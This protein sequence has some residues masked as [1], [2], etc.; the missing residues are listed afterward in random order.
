MLS[1]VLVGSPHGSR[2]NQ[3]KLQEKH[4]LVLAPD[5][6]CS[7]PIAKCT[8]SLRKILNLG[9][10]ETQNMT[11]FITAPDGSH[12]APDAKCA[13]LS[14]KTQD[15]KIMLAMAPDGSHHGSCLNQRK[16]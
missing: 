9:I 12:S 1:V 4:K 8:H 10:A 11:V 3:R 15:F 14:R 7:A 6:S 2:V 5:G 16:P 13:P